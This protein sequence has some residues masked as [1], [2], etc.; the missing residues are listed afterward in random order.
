MEESILITIK[1][2]IGIDEDDHSFDLDVLIHINAAIN[3][4]KQLGVGPDGGLIV[5]DETINWSD[6]LENRWD[7]ELVKA[8]MVLV[9]RK[10]FDPPQSSTTM[11]SI[12]ELID[13]YTWRINVTVDP[14]T[15]IS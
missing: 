15:K 3:T 13:Q 7:L 5:E 6:L 14:E 12:N 4:L 11:Q 9:V 10:G 2:L 8:W 1:K